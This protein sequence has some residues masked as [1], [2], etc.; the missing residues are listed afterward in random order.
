VDEE[1]GLPL[2]YR[3]YEGHTPDVVTLGAS[4]AGCWS[5]LSP[6]R[7]AHLTLIW[8]RATSR[9]NFQARAKAQCSFLAAIPTGWVRQFSRVP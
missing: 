8:T 7:F 4:L 6:A 5:I 3:C 1:Q 2:Y 9:A